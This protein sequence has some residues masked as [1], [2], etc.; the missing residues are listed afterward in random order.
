MAVVVNG[1]VDFNV[2]AGHVVAHPHCACGRIFRRALSNAGGSDCLPWVAIA[3]TTAVDVSL[4]AEQ[5]Q[6]RGRF[7]RGLVLDLKAC[8][9]FS[10]GF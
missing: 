6:R 3:T 8:C 4:F 10:L 7:G 5:R 2:P 1:D 9:Y